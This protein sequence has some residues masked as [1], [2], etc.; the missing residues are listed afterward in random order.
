MS[1]DDV[2]RRLEDFVRDRFTV[3]DS[4]DRFDRTVPLFQ[5]GYVDSIGVVELLAFL[6]EEFGVRVP[7]DVLLDD[8]FE[9]IEGIAATVVRLGD[10]A[11]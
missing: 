3:A 5:R 10:G 9:T 4:D 1:R 8:S 11:G 6:E 7:D 2:E